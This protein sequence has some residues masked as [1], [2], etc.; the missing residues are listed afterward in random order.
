M[1]DELDYNV[2]YGVTGLKLSE[3]DIVS[4]DTRILSVEVGFIYQATSPFQITINRK[5]TGTIHEP[6]ERV[7]FI[8]Y[9]PIET[10]TVVKVDFV[11]PTVFEM[12]QKESITITLPPSRFCEVKGHVS[13]LASESAEYNTR[14][15]VS[16]S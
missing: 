2:K 8:S 6:T 16:L 1:A 14:L 11:E 3:P 4:E 10:R 7:F 15:E 12:G 9:E 13:G 5:F